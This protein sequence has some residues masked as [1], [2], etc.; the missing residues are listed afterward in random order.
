MFPSFQIYSPSDT[1]SYLLKNYDAIFM[2]NIDDIDL[3]DILFASPP[4]R[5]DALDVQSFASDT[6]DDFEHIGNTA[7]HS[8]C[9][10]S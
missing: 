1:Q 3:L 6:L 2:D 8:F 9:I 7:A 10:V 5:S 4:S